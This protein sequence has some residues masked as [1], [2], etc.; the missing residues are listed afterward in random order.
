MIGGCS[1]TRPVIEVPPTDVVVDTVQ[2]RDEVQIYLTAV[3]DTT[4]YESVD[5]VARVPGFLER[6]LFT[7][8]KLVEKDTPLF[9]IE[10]AAYKI[11]LDSAEAQ[12]QVDEARAALSAANLERAESLYKQNKA[13]SEEEYQ[14]KVSEHKVALANIERTKTV[15]DKAKLDLS[16]TEIASPIPGKTTERLVDVGNYVGQGGAPT[17]L[18]TVTRLDP[19]YVDFAISD[20]EFNY[21]NKSTNF[22]KGLKVAK[23]E[24]QE[25]PFG[26]H[27]SRFASHNDDDSLD[28]C[29]SVIK[30][31]V[32]RLETNDTKTLAPEPKVL[33]ESKAKQI[34]PFEIAVLG[35][36]HNRYD[37]NFNGNLTSIIENG[38]KTQSG[39]ILI[40]GEMPN[41]KLD[42]FPGQIV[43]VRIPVEKVL[44]AVVVREEAILT[45]L[46]TKY[47]ITVE[48][49]YRDVVKRN[50][51][52]APIIGE[53][54]QPVKEQVPAKVA[55]RRLVKLGRKIDGGL[56]IVTAGLSGGESYVVSGVQK[57]RLDSAVN[58]VNDEQPKVA[59]P[60]TEKTEPATVN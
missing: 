50:V 3:G 13:V 60:T 21:Y 34:F 17:H 25:S 28:A 56:Q 43:R 23:S 6:V 59:E 5:I 8:G 19:I 40:R 24:P 53:D 9:L 30:P 46:D 48:D 57:V 31:V 4:S 14:T 49:G 42:I 37:Y 44:N 54:N 33:N 27:T 52:G 11:A 26:L 12:L 38:I 58:V 1:A 45:D 7:P 32:A 36:E 16:Y 2:V 47:V 35:D 22:V 18:V 15:V 51:N 39:Q 55:K 41:P 29:S 20:R 10:Q